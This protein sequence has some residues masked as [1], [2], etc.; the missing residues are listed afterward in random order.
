MNANTVYFKTLTKTN[1]VFLKNP[2]KQTIRYKSGAKEGQ[3]NKIVPIMYNRDYS[4]I[5]VSVLKAI[6]PTI[7]PTSL[8]SR[9]GVL[10]IQRDDV[11]L[12]LFLRASEQNEANGGKLF[13]EVDVVKEDAFQIDGFELYDKAINSVMGADKN[14]IKALALEFISPTAVHLSEQKIKL[15]I[16]QN[17][18]NNDQL[19]EAVNLFMSESVSEEKLAV[20]IA[21]K[22]K[23]IEIQEGRKFV[24]ADSKEVFFISPQASD[25][26]QA[27][28]LWLKN[29]KEGRTYLKA[30]SE[31][32]EAI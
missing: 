19:V 8:S 1:I 28:A 21:L 5:E 27:L 2:S 7:K 20:A 32:V 24:W 9:K 11:A 29:D 17:L 13:R 18:A 31:K 25:S 23:I 12:L 30:I 15:T 10:R 6:D 3:V 4:E 16:R 22:E 14:T 26:T